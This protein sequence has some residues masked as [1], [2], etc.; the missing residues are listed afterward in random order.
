MIDHILILRFTCVTVAQQ[1]YVQ[2]L[3]LYLSTPPCHCI[4]MPAEYDN[5]VLKRTSHLNLR[6]QH[7]LNSSLT[8][9]LD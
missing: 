1:D 3:T 5:K 6:T 2:R 9:G 8:L 7:P 4:A